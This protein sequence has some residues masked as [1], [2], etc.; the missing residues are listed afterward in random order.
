MR[1]GQTVGLK[2]QCRP[3]AESARSLL[4]VS[5]NK[6]DPSNLPQP[7][8]ATQRHSDVLQ[9]A[10]ELRRL[11]GV[12]LRY[13]RDRPELGL[14]QASSHCCQVAD[15]GCLECAFD[16]C[17]RMATWRRGGGVDSKLGHEGK[18]HD[19]VAQREHRGC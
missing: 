11:P 4:A 17:R 18:H 6:L 15:A 2:H 8:A 14:S 7:C 10:E 3:F 12:E 16:A 19:G 5:S 13:V 1:W 9:L